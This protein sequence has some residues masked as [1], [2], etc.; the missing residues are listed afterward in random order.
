MQIFKGCAIKLRDNI[1][2]LASK[3]GPLYLKNIKN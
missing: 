3:Y 2:F 1:I